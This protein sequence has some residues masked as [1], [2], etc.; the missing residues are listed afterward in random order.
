MAALASR[1]TGCITSAASIGPYGNSPSFLCPEL[2]ELVLRAEP[3][4]STPPRGYLRRPNLA[5]CGAIGP[6]VEQPSAFDS[7]VN[8]R[9]ATE[10]GLAIPQLVLSQATEIFQ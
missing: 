7:V 3:R 6:S 2:G 8:R 9:T 5:R 10:L 4:G 1:A